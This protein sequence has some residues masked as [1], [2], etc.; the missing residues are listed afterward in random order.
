MAP[1]MLPEVSYFDPGELGG[2][3]RAM[4]AGLRQTSD[5]VQAATEQAQARTLTVAD[6]DALAEVEVDGRPRVREI[7]LSRDA[8]RDPDRLDEVLTGLLNRALTQS[9]ENT[10]EAVLAALPPAVRRDAADLQEER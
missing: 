10:Q 5:Q 1:P 7:R 9:R 6:D 2:Q 3:L 4:A 8:R